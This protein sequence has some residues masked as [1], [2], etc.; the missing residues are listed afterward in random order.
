M[1]ADYRVPQAL[2]Y[3][4]ILKYSEELKKVLQSN[5]VLESGDRY[6]FVTVFG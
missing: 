5:T 3:F 6:Y 1:F 4:G 2:E